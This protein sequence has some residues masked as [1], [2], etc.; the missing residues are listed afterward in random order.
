MIPALAAD[1]LRGA[2]SRFATGVTIVTCVDAQGQ[3]FGLTVNSFSALSLDPPLV[4]WSLQH[5]SPSLAAFR[6]ATHFAVNVL[7]QAQIGLSRRFSSSHG[8]RFAEGVWS[9]GAGGAPVLAGSTAVFE[10]ATESQQDLGDHV[11]FIGRVLH[12]ADH[13]GAPLLF[14]SRRYHSLGGVV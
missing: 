9:A 1:A 11:L 14:Q 13:G 7:A 10:C 3:R 8:E 6:A 2:L 12:S 5:R 4:L